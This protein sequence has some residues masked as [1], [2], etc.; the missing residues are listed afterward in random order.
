MAA[1][2][3]GSDCEGPN[4]VGGIDDVMLC[5]GSEEDRDVRNECEE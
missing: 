5:N 4:A 1:H 3:T 2:L